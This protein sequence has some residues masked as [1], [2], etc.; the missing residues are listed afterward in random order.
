MASTT[1]ALPH[2][3]EYLLDPAYTSPDCVPRQ[4]LLRTPGENSAGARRSAPLCLSIPH[5][6]RPSVRSNDTLRGPGQG[7]RAQLIY[8]AQS[9][10]D[11]AAMVPVRLPSRFVPHSNLPPTP[12]SR[13]CWTLKQRTATT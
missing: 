10:D 9:V 1:R 13:T 11:E 8:G 6:L 7:G 2:F 3:S 12:L 5:G 4:R